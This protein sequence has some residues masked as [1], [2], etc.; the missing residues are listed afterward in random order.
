MGAGP[1]TGLGIKLA[2]G[3]APWITIG[4]GAGEGLYGTGLFMEFIIL[5][6]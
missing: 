2:L 5:G 3:D 4:A 1:D 6:T